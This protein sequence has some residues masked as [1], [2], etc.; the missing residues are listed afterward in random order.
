MAKKN[1]KVKTKVEG[2]NANWFQ[3]LLQ[4]SVMM[5]NDEPVWY[6]LSTKPTRSTGKKKRKNSETDPYITCRTYFCKL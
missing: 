3:G 6:W 1:L 4:A 2:L 5:S